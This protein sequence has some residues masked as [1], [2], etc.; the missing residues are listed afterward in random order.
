MR[1]TPR[2]CIRGSRPCWKSA[3]S[4]GST[5]TRHVPSS[6][7]GRAGTWCSSRPR[8]AARPCA[9]T[10]PCS[11]A[12]WS[13]PRPA[14]STSSP[15]RPWPT[16]RCTRCTASSGELKA[17]IRTFTYD[18]D[19]PDDARQAI[20]KQGHVVVTNPDMLHTA[21][22]RTTQVAEA[23]ANLRYVVVDELHIYRGVFG[24]HLT[25]VFRR[26]KRFGRFY[27]ADPVFVSARPPW[28]TRR[29]TP[30]TSWRRRWC[31]STRAGAPVERPLSCTTRPS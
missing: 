13:S 10:C 1:R 14:R 30:R 22:C 5:P 11:S 3:A 6:S 16:T 31:S 8:P 9:T 17:D 19:T 21:F 4:G 18:G 20:R 24:S 7:S 29:S 27:G 12:S 2:G 28:R 15:P 25:N 26:L 23:L